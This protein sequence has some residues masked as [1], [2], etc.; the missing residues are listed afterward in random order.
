MF[1]DFSMPRS[2]WVLDEAGFEYYSAWNVGV[3]ER[4]DAIYPLVLG[5][6]PPFPPTTGPQIFF[7]YPILYS[8]MRN[9][10]YGEN[11][12]AEQ[13]VDIAFVDNGLLGI[14]ISDAFLVSIHGHTGFDKILWHVVESDNTLSS[15]NVSLPLGTINLKVTLGASG[16]PIGRTNVRFYVNDQEIHNGYY[17]FTYRDC[18]FHG[19]M[20][21]T[22]QP[23]DLGWFDN[24]SMTIAVPAA[25]PI[26]DPD[27]TV[28]FRNLLPNLSFQP[29]PVKTPS[30]SLPWLLLPAMSEHVTIT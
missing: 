2:G 13:E 21:R 6:L 8:R 3:N 19:M 27:D 15:G 9:S 20:G 25:G 10:P 28:L 22:F 7:N 18:L 26:E 11:W 24:Y 17:Q 30:K 14:F 5:S 1:D 4:I 12:A 23:N 29:Q 16:P